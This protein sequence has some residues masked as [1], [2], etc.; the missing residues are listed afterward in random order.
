LIKQADTIQGQDWFC[1]VD[2]LSLLY[3][4]I[5]GNFVDNTYKPDSPKN[6]TD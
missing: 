6:N 3:Y 5:I 2:N 1:G 4:N